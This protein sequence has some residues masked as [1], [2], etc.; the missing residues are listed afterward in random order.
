MATII[1]NNTLREFV[2]SYLFNKSELPDDLKDIPIGRWIVTN[3]TD[4]NELFQFD[5]SDDDEE[6]AY[7]LF[8][9]PLDGWDVSNVRTMSSM[10]FGC[11]NFNQPLDGWNVSSVKD[12]SYMFCGCTNF[13]QPLN[14]WNVSN[15]TNM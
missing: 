12:M 15:V 3:V 13:N 4:M 9:E 8:N 6:E 14:G 10:F 2:F 11:I 7:K 1:D 5:V